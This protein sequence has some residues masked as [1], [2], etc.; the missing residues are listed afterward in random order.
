[1]TTVAS[2][3][4]RNTEHLG[5]T[6]LTKLRNASS[7]YLPPDS[8][9]RPLQLPSQHSLSC[10]HPPQTAVEKP[11]TFRTRVTFTTS[12]NTSAAARAPASSLRHSVRGNGWYKAEPQVP[13]QLSSQHKPDQ[14]FSW[15]PLQPLTAGAPSPLSYFNSSLVGSSGPQM[16]ALFLSLNSS[17]SAHESCHYPLS[18]LVSAH[19]KSPGSTPYWILATGKR[20]GRKKIFL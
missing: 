11:F 15:P 2:S 20:Q 7:A 10:L 8:P 9:A 16:N 17:P 3:P 1:M 13:S 5:L 19:S 14:Q 18:L 12:S 6:L 4:N